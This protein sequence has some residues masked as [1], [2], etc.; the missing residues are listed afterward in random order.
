ME[1]FN[2]DESMKGKYGYTHILYIFECRH[3]AAE[4][5]DVLDIL[6]RVF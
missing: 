2:W 4:G 1:R 3:R 6:L 5:F